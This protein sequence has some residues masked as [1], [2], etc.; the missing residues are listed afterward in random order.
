M[1][2]RRALPADR[3]NLPHSFPIY[4]A[5]ESDANVK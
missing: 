1:L 5:I 3:Q 4:V 2:L